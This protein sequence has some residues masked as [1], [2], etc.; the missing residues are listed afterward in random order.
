MKDHSDIVII[1]G[2]VA[3]L[4][5]GYRLAPHASVTLLETEDA[6]AYHA[7]GRSAALYEKNYGLASTVALSGASA[8]FFLSQT[9]YVSPRGFMLI[10]KAAH[11]DAFAIQSRAM[12]L[13]T[14]TI[15]EARRRV[16]ILNEHVTLAAYHEDAWDIDTDRMLQDFA[17]VIRHN[18]GQVLLKTPVRSISRARNWQITTP[19]GEITADILINAA[20]PWGDQIAQMAGVAPLGLTPKRRSMARIKAPGGHDVSQWPMV[21]ACGE[22]WYA[23]PD[24]GALIISPEDA[25]PLPPQDAWPDDM[26]LAEGLSRY[27]SHVTI[28]VTRPISQWAGLRTFSLDG[29]L[30]IGP[31]PG[32]P[33]YFWQVGLGGYGFQTA[34]AA[35]QLGADL[36]LG[37]SPELPTD[38]IQTLLPERFR[39]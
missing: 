39:T 3:G 15:T 23:K 14:I 31:E 20:G 35:S 27:E 34:P 30:A 5:L 19:Q 10:A 17:R 6:L 9:D 29:N 16:P 7:S 36:I 8:D 37:R 2:G 32:V 18:N 12:A 38:L 21:F 33:G 28:P 1:G 13:T 11:A 24:A 22:P 4:S 26:V 25:D